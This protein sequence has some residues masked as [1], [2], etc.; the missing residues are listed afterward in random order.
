MAVLKDIPY[1]TQVSRGDTVVT[2]GFSQAFPENT[3][4]GFV[5]RVEH[6]QNDHTLDISVRLA[7]DMTNL[8]WVYVHTLKDDPELEELN[9]MLKEE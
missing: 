1:Q 2:S 3:V 7:A 8:G 6:R 5:E 4:A 9:G